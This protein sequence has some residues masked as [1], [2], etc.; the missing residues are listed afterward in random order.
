MNKRI[1][2]IC[3]LLN[4][5]KN[6]SNECG[7]IEVGIFR[8]KEVHMASDAFFRYFDRY[9]ID[10]TFSQKEHKKLYREINGVCFFCI[11]EKEGDVEDE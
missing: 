1:E 10:R 5:I 8:G 9:E 2:R 4:E 3:E 7:L 6:L 11:M